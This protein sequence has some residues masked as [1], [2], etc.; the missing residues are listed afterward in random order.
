L[1]L[2]ITL[3][4]TA[5]F[6]SPSCSNQINSLPRIGLKVSP[7]RATNPREIRNAAAARAFPLAGISI[8]VSPR[9]D[10][11]GN[12]VSE[13]GDGVGRGLAVAQH[14]GAGGTSHV[15][16]DA[17]APSHGIR[18][19]FRLTLAVTAHSPVL[20]KRPDQPQMRTRR[21]RQS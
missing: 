13:L 11:A 1:I 17:V 20:R 16:A 9:G 4:T 8:M 5:W 12:P 10:Q 2:E 6:T 7:M 21:A 18:A 15:A 19:Q 14:R 3:V